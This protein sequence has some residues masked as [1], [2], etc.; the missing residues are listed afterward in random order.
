MDLNGKITKIRKK[1]AELESSV[2]E[3]MMGYI[4]AAFGLVA[5]LAWND[6]IKSLIESLFPAGG[7]SVYAKFIYA[8]LMTVVV[9]V[10][11]RALIRASVVRNKDVS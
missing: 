2:R 8:A 6:A 3:K 9:V 1:G 4:T 10:V 7:D 5:G 11:T